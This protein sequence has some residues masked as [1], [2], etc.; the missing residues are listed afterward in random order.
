MRLTLVH[1]K[2]IHTFIFALLSCCVLYVVA[3]GA[4]NRVSRWTWVAVVAI[5]VEGLVLIAS[6][7]RRPLTTVAERLGA[8]NGSVA[9]TFLPPW[10][11]DRIFTICTTVFLIG[12]ALVLARLFRL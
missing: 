11:A 3:S 7:G 12:C 5:V 6:G 9:D 4:L 10:F 1:I 8:A 2:L